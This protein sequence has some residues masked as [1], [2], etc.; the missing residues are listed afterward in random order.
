VTVEY[1]GGVDRGQHA[2]VVVD[3][4]ELWLLADGAVAA[5]GRID[6]TEGYTL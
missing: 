6:E 5:S 4:H 3:G 2:E 1:R